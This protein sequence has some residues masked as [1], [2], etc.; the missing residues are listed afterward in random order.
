M[1]TEVFKVDLYLPVSASV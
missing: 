1:D